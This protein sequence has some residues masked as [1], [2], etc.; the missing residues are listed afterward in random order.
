MLRQIFIGR[1]LSHYVARTTTRQTLNS[2]NGKRAGVAEEEQKEHGIIREAR[3]GLNWALTRMLLLTIAVL[4]V[5]STSAGAWVSG[6]YT[7]SYCE[8]S[9]VHVSSITPTDYSSTIVKV[10]TTFSFYCSGGTPGTVW[11]IQT[12][13][14]AQSSLVGVS[15]ISGSMN[16]YSFGQGT[17][18]YVVNNQFDAMN[19]YG[20]GD[21][22]PSLYVQITAINSSTGS[23]DAQ[24]QAPFAVDTS[25]YPFN[26]AQQNYCHF[27]GLSQFFQLL[28]GCGAG[29]V[30]STVSTVSTQAVPSTSNCNTFGLPQFL[31]PYL[32][33]CG[34]T[35]N[36][37]V[38]PNQS[39]SP[40]LPTQQAGSPLTS[41]NTLPTPAATATAHDRSIQAVLGII[42]SALATLLVVTVILKRP[43]RRRARLQGKFCP[44]CG[45]HLQATANFCGR[46][47][48]PCPDDQ[49]TYFFRL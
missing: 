31:Q 45:I 26:L 42:I 10:T 25:Q 23:L 21:Q 16:Q 32:P 6:D 35:G 18:Q 14:Y 27:P 41:P 34:G 11:D 30:N 4:T 46:C 20:Y 36:K 47:G 33:G 48:E 8:I 37:T 39:S 49:E 9:N 44:A 15:P 5:T 13:V 12:R 19:Y 3:G 40:Q 1:G 43:T 29:S 28:P 2:V 17:A 38:A 24:Q 22:T 7:P